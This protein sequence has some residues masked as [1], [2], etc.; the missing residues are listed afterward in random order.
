MGH[1]Q[2]APAFFSMAELPAPPA[3]VVPVMVV[4]EP[5]AGIVPANAELQP[6]PLVEAEVFSLNCFWFFSPRVSVPQCLLYIRLVSSL[7][8]PCRRVFILSSF[9]VFLAQAEFC[10]LGYI[11]CFVHLCFALYLACSAQVFPSSPCIFV[12][13]CAY[14]SFEG[15]CSSPLCLQSSRL[16][17]AFFVRFVFACVNFPFSL[18]LEL[19]L[20]S[21]GYFLSLLLR[22]RF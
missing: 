19:P 8:F 16:F 14:I 18:S 10:I 17:L 7:G 20:C 4:E 22:F 9:R 15:V 1:R 5:A 3:P 13:P 6:P 2:P 12:V 11:Y 21:E